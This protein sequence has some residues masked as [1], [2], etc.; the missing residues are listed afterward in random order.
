MLESV[1]R[2]ERYRSFLRDSAEGGTKQTKTATGS[3]VAVLGGGSVVLVLA[4]QPSASVPPTVFPWEETRAVGS[5]R[6][7]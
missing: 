5:P 2:V 7:R 4:R 1:Q 3:M 6:R